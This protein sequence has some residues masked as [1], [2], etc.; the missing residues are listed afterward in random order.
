MSTLTV[1]H[2]CPTLAYRIL[3]STPLHTS[4]HDYIGHSRANTTGQ[5]QHNRIHVGV[6]HQRPPA[7]STKESHISK[8]IPQLVLNT[9]VPNTT[10]ADNHTVHRFLSRNTTA[11]VNTYANQHPIHTSRYRIPTLP[12]QFHTIGQSDQTG[13]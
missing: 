13:V 4:S 10:L 5:R 9:R 8:H 7:I 3:R 1:H 6:N 11:L 2:S 12:Q